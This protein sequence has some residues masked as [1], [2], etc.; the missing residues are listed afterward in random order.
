MEKEHSTVADRGSLT[1]VPVGCL[2]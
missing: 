2:S 1:P